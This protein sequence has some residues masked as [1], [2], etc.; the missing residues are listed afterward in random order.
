MRRNQWAAVL[1]A[2]LLFCC[3]VAAG[4]LADRYYNVETVA[5][6]ANTP[7]NARKHYIS[8]MRSRLN[9]TP[10]QVGQLETIMDETDA[11]FRAVREK[12]HPEMVQVHREHIDHVK[13]ILTARQ[14]PIYEQIVKE[15]Q[16][17]ERKRHEQENHP[18]HGH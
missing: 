12:Y 11:Q 4:V 7:E 16:E 15:H 1:F 5:A 3:G 10:T 13:A 6:K 8:F 18:H 14:I 9:L 2:L 17:Q